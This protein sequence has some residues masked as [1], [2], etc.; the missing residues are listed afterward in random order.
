MKKIRRWK[1]LWYFINLIVNAFEYEFEVPV[2]I[3]QVDN[4]SKIVVE[5]DSEFLNIYG[6]KKAALPV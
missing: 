6:T 5:R 3:I 1:Y 4:S 2:H